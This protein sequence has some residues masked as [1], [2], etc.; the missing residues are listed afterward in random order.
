MEGG[1]IKLSFKHLQT[2]DEKDILTLSCLNFA[3]GATWLL[4][5]SFIKSRLWFCRSWSS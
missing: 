1:A 2:Q 5:F 4:R 3:N